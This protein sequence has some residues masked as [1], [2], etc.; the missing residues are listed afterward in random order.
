MKRKIRILTLFLIP[1]L[2]FTLLI[3][4]GLA[5]NEGDVGDDW[6]YKV[7]QPLPI[8][9]TNLTHAE[10]A[11]NV[12]VRGDDWNYACYYPPVETTSCFNNS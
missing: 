5:S 11:A 10:L 1:F 12:R 3:H 2:I 4:M 9:K 6:N 7:S 8:E